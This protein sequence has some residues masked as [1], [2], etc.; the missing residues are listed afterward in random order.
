[1]A[2]RD[3]SRLSSRKIQDRSLALLLI[4]LALFMPPIGAAFTVDATIAGLPA[5]LLMLF[6]VWSLLI[7]GAAWLARRLL[8]SDDAMTSGPP[9]EGGR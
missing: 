9:S 6:F 4:G 7:A 8:A 1:M 5:P 2:K 3:V